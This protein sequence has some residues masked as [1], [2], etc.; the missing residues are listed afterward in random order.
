LKL[1]GDA[2]AVEIISQDAQSS[3]IRISEN[4]SFIGTDKQAQRV[5]KCSSVVHSGLYDMELIADAGRK[6]LIQ[7][8]ESR[9]VSRNEYTGQGV[10]IPTYSNSNIIELK[11]FGMTGNFIGLEQIQIRKNYDRSKFPKLKKRAP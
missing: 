5:G 3:V 8:D 4:N 6:I 9:H 11:K 7:I 10:I 1:L 2:T